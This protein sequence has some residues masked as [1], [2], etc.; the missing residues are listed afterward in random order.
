M[1]T[2]IPINE[3]LPPEDHDVLVCTGAREVTVAVRF[4][5]D[6]L[7]L[8]QAGSKYLENVEFWADLPGPPPAG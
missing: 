8:I 7:R 1:T 5:K 2:W 4:G 6:W 3:K